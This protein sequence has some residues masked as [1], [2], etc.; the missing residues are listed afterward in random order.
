MFY[1]REIRFKNRISSTRCNEQIERLN[2]PPAAFVERAGA[3]RDLVVV[4]GKAKR[5]VLVRRPRGRR[6]QRTTFH[7]SAQLAHGFK[8]RSLQCETRSVRSVARIKSRPNFHPSCPKKEPKQF[9]CTK[10]SFLSSTK[11]CLIFG[12]DFARQNV[13]KTFQK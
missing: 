8:G 13:S 7:A 11:S 10:R 12:V 2:G 6:S 1:Q 3:G 9:V 4:V 5:R